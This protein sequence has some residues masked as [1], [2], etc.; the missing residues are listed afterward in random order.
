M[1]I[2]EGNCTITAGSTSIVVPH[3][4][5]VVPSQVTVQPKDDLTGRNWYIPDADINA[6]NFTL[7][8]SGMDFVDHVFRWFIAD[9]ANVV[10]GVATIVAGSESVT[11]L[12]LFGSAPSSVWLRP[13]DDLGGRDCSVD[14][15][16]ITATQL[17]VHISFMDAVDHNF[18]FICKN[19]SLLSEGNATV[20]AGTT[21]IVVNHGHGSTP[22]SV[23]VQQKSDLA[24]VDAYVDYASITSTQFTLLL[25][26]PSFDP[27]D[28]RFLCYG[29]A[30]PVPPAYSVTLGGISLN[31]SE[32]GF[33][34]TKQLIT[35]DWKSWAVSLGKAVNNLLIHGAYRTWVLDCFEYE[36]DWASSI[37]PTLQAMAEVDTSYTLIIALDILHQVTCSVKVRGARLLY[38]SGT[39]VTSRHREFEVV[40][41]E[42]PTV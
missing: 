20:A 10:V 18:Q 37:I 32:D 41:E 30:P 36:T 31:V 28:F 38:P 35:L 3:G 17:T 42:V 1:T 13:K 26:G 7:R 16:T 15:A 21:S 5:G 25:N 33:H 6:S 23:W 34:E 27:Y 2:C 29:V 12:H 11:V 9:P 19:M 8:I 4:Y 40:C 22:S 39:N 24:G 14:Y